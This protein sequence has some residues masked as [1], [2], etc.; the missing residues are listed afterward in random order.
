M[1]QVDVSKLIGRWVHSHEESQED[2][3]VLRH[4][5]YPLA[6]S[7]GRMSID[8]SADGSCQSRGPGPDDR[9]TVSPGRWELHGKLLTV[10]ALFLGGAYYV[11]SVDDGAL[12][13]RRR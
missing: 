6:P 12:V 9:T 10:D 3:V 2:R 1:G 13:L 11:E 5:D 8:L 4:P 7:R